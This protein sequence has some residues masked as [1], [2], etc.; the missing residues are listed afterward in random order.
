MMGSL[1]FFVFMLDTAAYQSWQEDQDYRHPSNS[2]VGA[3]PV[4]Q[5]TGSGQKIIALAG[6]LYPEVTGGQRSLDFLK[7]MGAEGKS[8]PLITGEGTY[9]GAFVIEKIGET[10]TYFFSDGAC[11]KIE[12][13]LNLKHVGS[14][15]DN[16]L[17]DMLNQVLSFINGVI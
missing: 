5:F 1:G 3:P 16:L 8:Y 15:P 17:G 13:N 7:W 6:T 14:K 11:R 9:H 4:S 12:F 2:I 10:K